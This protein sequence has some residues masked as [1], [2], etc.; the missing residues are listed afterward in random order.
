VSDE[1][2]RQSWQIG[3]SPTPQKLRLVLSVLQDRYW[4]V[5]WPRDAEAN[6]PSAP[7]QHVVHRP[8]LLMGNLSIALRQSQILS[9]NGNIRMSCEPL[10]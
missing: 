1:G 7:W 6:V 9:Q 8:I 3:S 4:L 10:Q 5:V 2:G